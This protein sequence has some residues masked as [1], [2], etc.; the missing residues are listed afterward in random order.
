MAAQ[1][2]ASLLQWGWR[3]FDTAKL[4]LALVLVSIV[5]VVGTALLVLHCIKSFREELKG[6]LFAL[7]WLMRWAAR[8]GMVV[9]AGWKL[10]DINE[11]AQVVTAGHLQRAHDWAQVALRVHP[12]GAAPR[13]PRARKPRAAAPAAPAPSPTT[14]ERETEPEPAPREAEDGWGEWFRKL[15]RAPLVHEEL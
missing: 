11:E 14:E 1:S 10:F 15:T 3:S 4:E 7:G 9:L 8:A 2:F 5:C 12:P 6:V 13:A